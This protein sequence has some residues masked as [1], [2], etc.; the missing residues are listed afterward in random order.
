MT[1]LLLAASVKRC[2]TSTHRNKTTVIPSL[3]KRGRVSEEADRR[4]F[5]TQEEV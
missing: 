1:L 2:D 4:S 3:A 5:C